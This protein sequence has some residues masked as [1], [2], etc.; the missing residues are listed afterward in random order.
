[1]VK[2]A[3]YLLSSLISVKAGLLEPNRILSKPTHKTELIDYYSWQRK[4]D[5]LAD[6]TIEVYTKRL[7][8]LAK[9]ADLSKPEEVKT[10][11]ASGNQKNS[12]KKGLCV[13]YTDFLKFKGLKWERPKYKKEQTIPFIPLEKEID[14]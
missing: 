10:A 2:K 14:A 12:H 8:T 9:I 3:Y 5:G 6:Q 7:K 13:A 4:K 11:I 1:V